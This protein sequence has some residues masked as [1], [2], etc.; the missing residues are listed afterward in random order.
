[1]TFPIAKMPDEHRIQ[2]TIRAVASNSLKSKN[3][4]RFAMRQIGVACLALLAAVPTLSLATL[5]LSQSPPTSGGSEPAP[6]VIITVDD[7]GSMSQNV[8]GGE[9]H[10]GNDNA[11]S[12][13]ITLLKNSLVSQFGNGTSTNKGR[14]V[15][16]R[17]R[18]AWQA[19]HNNGNASGAASLTPGATNAMRSF[20]GT[21]RTNFN[22]FVTS[23]SAGQNTPSHLMIKQAYD[24]MRT[25]EGVNSPWADVPGTTQTTP[26]LSCRR[27]YHIF[28][29]DGGW[30]ASPTQSVGNADGTL[31]TL[32]DGV[33]SY[34]PT[35]AQVK[36]YTDPWGGGN[37]GPSTLADFA[38]AGW[39]TDLQDGSSSTQAM[40]NGVKPLIKKSGVEVVGGVSLAEFWNPKND[41][42]TWQHIVTHTIGF[43]NGATSWTDTG[44]HT[45]R[46]NWDSLTNNTY[47][48]D[49]P[50][51]VSGAVTWPDPIVSLDING[52][53][54]EL[55]HMALN[56]RGKFYPAVDATALTAAFSDILDNIIADTSRPLVSIAASS[57]SLRSG[58]SA[59]LA[60]YAPLDWSGQLSARPI[61]STT[62]AIG[63]TET[64][65][66][67]ALLDASVST[68]FVLSYS[69]TAGIAWTTYT[70]LPA[71]QQTPL[72]KNSSGIVD[73][74]GQSRVDYL[75]GDRSK[76]ASQA[77]GVFR[78]RGSRLG[79]I[80]NS[81]LWYT[82][83]PA[84]GYTFSNYANFR[85]TTATG[86]KG[87]RTPMIY[88]GAN[89]GMLHGFAANDGQEKLAYIPQGVAQGNLRH[90]TDTGY[91]HQYFV[92][93]SPFTGDAYIGT[94][95][96]WT[97]VLVGSL[98]AGGKGYFVLDVTDPANFTTA[99]VASLVITDTT[100]TTDA[101]IGSITSPPVVDDAI[102]GKSRQIVRMNNG[103]WAAVLGNGYNSTN[104][105][106]VLLIQYLDGDKAMVKVSPCTQPI[107]SN[108]CSFKGNNGL[109]SPQ[110]IDLNGDG[111]VDIAYAGDLKGNVW[112]FN[113]T[114]ATDTNWSV[115]FKDTSN[116]A[117]PFFVAKTV[118]SV[119]QPITTAPFWMPH[120]NGGI[121]LAVST[122][123]NLTVADQTSTGTDTVYGLYD[124]STFSFGSS[125][126]SITDA[127]AINTTSSTGLPSTL[128]QQTITGTL[129][130]AG[131]TYFTSSNNAV[132]FSTK[133]GWY[134]N[135]SVGGQRVLHNSRAFS[136]QKILIQST[137]PKTGGTTGV[138]SCSP[139]STTE[140]SFL[141]VFNMFTGSPSALPAFTLTSTSNANTNV[142]TIENNPGGDNWILRAGE[143]VKILRTCPVGQTCIP[144]ELNPDK[145]IGMRSNWREIQ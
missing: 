106:P 40:V 11:A 30:N 72:N 14:L 35:S 142:T 55:W 103:R 91:S 105:A 27:T 143:K 5:I 25:P 117:Q 137:V 60:G 126:V 39:A 23:L 109:S 104:E 87:G 57:S 64:W 17:I 121:M 22:T 15:D 16:G 13:K 74:N 96:A 56:G 111:K 26:Y 144:K 43:G 71:A 100:A 75:R 128:V 107:T 9:G 101:D 84:S 4:E 70:A 82:G 98:G 122:G 83:K 131:T 52:R 69:G 21:H 31:R 93:G 99:N 62:G 45:F 6:N 53:P 65:N 34:D 47:G 124:N 10:D 89:D 116:Q 18:L 46:P 48:G 78:N 44:G 130:D 138:E 37:A 129:T 50:S 42:A 139:A 77:G 86:G 58:L 29:T 88:I 68:R 59:Y 102:A 145:Y 24:Y 95:P 133:R 33:T 73:N 136:G 119:T 20:S 54:V 123:Q 113:L 112:K 115:A 19:M 32:G 108:A 132:D 92:D 134:L 120:P 140:R 141:S 85:S 76:E 8:T 110:L 38:F 41:P 7:S 1:M 127:T 49:Y 63:S 114:S 67:A 66:A 12:T 81:N 61:D 97:T 36:Q 94:A 3:R 2:K 51:L 90:L 125:G 80:V 135:W 118:A 28:M 79:D